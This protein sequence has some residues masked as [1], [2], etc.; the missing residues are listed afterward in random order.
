MRIWTFLAAMLLAAPAHAGLFGSAEYRRDSGEPT[1]NWRAMMARAETSVCAPVMVVAARPFR[2]VAPGGVPVLTPS[3]GCGKP[4]F[5]AKALVALLAN[6]TPVAQLDTVNAVVNRVPYVEDRVNYGTE[7]YWATP[8]EF[9]ARG[10]DCEDYAIA[11][12][13]LLRRAGVPADAMRVAV[14][15]DLALGTSHAIL[16]VEAG[17]TTWI[18][19]NQAVDVKPADAV[20]RYQPVYSI[21][22]NGWWLHMPV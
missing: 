6:Q 12:Y 7:D 13:M 2:D 9:I 1:A 19:D 8:A 4:A 17:G 20:T 5:D 11:K 14:V 15:R 16:A 21:N 10:G 3:S 22:E 18:L